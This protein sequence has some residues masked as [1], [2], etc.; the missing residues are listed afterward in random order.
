MIAVYIVA[1]WIGQIGYCILLVLAHKEETKVVKFP[2]IVI[3]AK[4]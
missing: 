1:I 3:D 2:I 4:N